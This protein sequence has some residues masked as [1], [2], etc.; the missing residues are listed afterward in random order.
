MNSLDIEHCIFCS[1]WML[2]SV[3]VSLITKMLCLGGDCSVRIAYLLVFLRTT[4]YNKD[5][6]NMIYLDGRLQ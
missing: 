5:M 3:L 1:V 2:L 4:L 6:H